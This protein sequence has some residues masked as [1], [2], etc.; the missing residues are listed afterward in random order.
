[1]ALTQAFAYHWADYLLYYVYARVLNSG[2]WGFSP[3]Q[4]SAVANPVW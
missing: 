4:T 3:D 1:M 2:L